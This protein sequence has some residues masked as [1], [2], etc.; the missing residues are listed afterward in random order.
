MTFTLTPKRLQSLEA[1]TTLAQNLMEQEGDTFHR[2]TPHTLCQKLRQNGQGHLLVHIRDVDGSDTQLLILSDLS[3][4]AHNTQQRV[5]HKQ[6]LFAFRWLPFRNVVVEPHRL[7]FVQNKN[8][9]LSKTTNTSPRQAWTHTSRLTVNTSLLKGL[10]L[11]SAQ[12]HLEKRPEPNVC[13]LDHFTGKDSVP[14][15]PHPPDTPFHTL[16][17]G[18]LSFARNPPVAFL[19][20]WLKTWLETPE[21]TNLFAKAEEDVKTFLLSL[22][23]EHTCTLIECQSTPDMPQ[24]KGSTSVDLVAR[25]HHEIPETTLVTACQDLETIVE[26]LCSPAPRHRAHLQNLKPDNPQDRVPKGAE[27]WHRVD[28][29]EIPRL[30]LILS[31]KDSESRHDS[32]ALHN[33]QSPRWNHAW[34]I[35]QQ[36]RHLVADL[37]PLLAPGLKRRWQ[38]QQDSA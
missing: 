23:L 19:K 13:V 17:L 37:F 32:V 33:P 1:K 36:H 25:P 9:S 27:R 29:L 10:P 15:L 26:N 24:K 6:S 16:I 4:L 31:F 22:G 2:F 28:L 5:W 11:L 30:R 7:V 34:D 21:D 3:F 20:P 8:T 35:L 18:S 38:S 12:G 14:L